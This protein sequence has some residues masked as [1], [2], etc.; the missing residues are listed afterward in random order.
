MLNANTT[1]IMTAHHFGDAVGY[2]H[3]SAKT[4]FILVRDHMEDTVPCGEW[5]K[6]CTVGS[7]AERSAVVRMIDADAFDGDP[8]KLPSNMPAEAM[9][10]ALSSEYHLSGDMQY[11]RAQ[12]STFTEHTPGE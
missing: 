5:G 6:L 12:R 3:E 9:A 7:S 11:G 2:V 10:A 4:G 1:K 8:M